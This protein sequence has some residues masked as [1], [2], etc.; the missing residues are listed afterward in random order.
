MFTAQAPTNANVDS[1]AGAFSFSSGGS[2][3]ASRD[4]LTRDLPGIDGATPSRFASRPPSAKVL[5]V[6]NQ[7][8][9]MTQNG[10]EVADALEAA[11]KSCT[12]LVLRQSLRQIHTSVS[13]GASLAGAFARHGRDFPRTLPAVLAASEASGETPAAI[14]RVVTRMRSELQMRSTLVG[15]MIYPAILIGVS[16]LVIS[17]LV[18]GVLPQ[19]QKV[20][21]SL[22]KPVPTSTAFLLAI[23]DWGR[24]YWYLAGGG[25]VTAAVLAWRYRRSD[26]LRR[27][28][29]H[30]LTHGPLIRHAYRPLV[31]GQTFRTLGA[32]IG[33]GVPMLEAV[34]LTRRATIDPG[35]RDL[36][37]SME[38]RLIDGLPPSGCLQEATFLP[39]EAAQM[40]AT[41][42]MTGRLADV[43]ED[44]GEFYEEEASRQMKR[45]IVAIEPAI[46]LVMGIMVGGIVLSVM[47]PMLDVTSTR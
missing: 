5:L 18:L 27:P 44:M 22:N 39:S 42:E 38:D 15:A 9:V 3:A 10:V 37:T 33:G 31:T 34:R 43:L 6:L 26:H 21:E 25:V 24:Q 14:A 7:L 46:I 13:E 36:L 32:M 45:L 4:S 17:A 23:G 30:V 12:H 35:W 41:G 29:F 2:S 19:F 28:V 8:A 16:M 47:L 1:P 11:A 20:F 40:M